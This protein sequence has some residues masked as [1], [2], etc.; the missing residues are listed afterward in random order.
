MRFFN[1][2]FCACKIEK[3]KE[4]GMRLYV[5]RFGKRDLFDMNTVLINKQL[6]MPHSYYY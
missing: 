3:L 5:T 1:V 6:K 4:P 2:C